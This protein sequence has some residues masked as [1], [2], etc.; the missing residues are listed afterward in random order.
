MNKKVKISLAINILIVLLTIFSLI[1]IFTG[2]KFMESGYSTNT[3]PIGRFKFFTTQ[4][5]VFMGTVAFIFAIY[6]IKLIKGKISEIS[7]KMYVV[8]LMS[9]VAVGLTFVT[10]FGY[11]GIIVEG[12]VS[13]LL[14][15]SSL[16][17]H[18]I[19]PVLSMLNFAVFERSNKIKFKDNLYSILPTAAYGMFY[20]T[21]VIVHIE[22]GKVSLEHDWYCFAQGGLWQIAIVVPL[23]FGVTYLISII[24]WRI[25]RIKYYANKRM[26]FTHPFKNKC[27]FFR[28]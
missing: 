4:S 6:E 11:L 24:L 23:M 2:F 25:N 18:L 9:T 10:V 5:N 7:S 20:L 26:C 17:F 28:T 12:G 16:F 13:Q 3:T 27:N 14:R 21:N 15:N 19:I 8:K 1:I 22:D